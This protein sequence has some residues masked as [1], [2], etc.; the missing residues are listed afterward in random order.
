MDPSERRI[1]ALHLA[2]GWAKLLITLSTGA[3]ALG[4]TF[5]KDIFKGEIT[6]SYLIITSWS[7]FGLSVIFGVFHVGGLIS[8]LNS[9]F[10]S[11]VD[12]DSGQGKIFRT[13][14]GISFFLGVIL[15]V[16]FAS[17]NIYTRSEKEEDIRSYF[18]CIRDNEAALSTFF[19]AMPK[20]G[21]LHNHFSGSVYAETYWQQIIDQNFYIDTSSLVVIKTLELVDP[22]K[23]GKFVTM[24]SLKARKRLPIYQNKLIREWSIKDFDKSRASAANH[25]FDSFKK[26]PGG[27]WSEIET[28]MKEIADRAEKE[29]VQYIEIMVKSVSF[30]IKPDATWNSRLRSLW[31]KNDTTE[32][33]NSLEELTGFLKSNKIDDYVKQHVD[34]IN[35][36]HEK[37]KDRA[38]TFRYLSFIKR[39]TEPSLAFGGLL[40][41]FQAAERSNLIVGVNI[42]ER[43]DGPLSMKDYD[44]HMVMFRYLRS[45]FPNVK[46]SLHAGELSLGLVKPEDLTSHIR[47][48]LFIAGAHRIGHGVDISYEENVTEILTFM[49]RKKIP[50]EINLSSN[51]FILDVKGNHHPISLYRKYG[52]P[53]VISTDDAGILRTNLAHQ[54]VLLATRYRSLSYDDIKSII[55]NSID[56]SFIEED[57]LRKDLR[58]SLVEKMEMFEKS[59]IRID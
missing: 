38:V 31:L 35:M 14:Q 11:N 15:F 3:I 10:N 40:A 34:Q 39:E 37:L 26:F 4:G 55:F 45:K 41:A 28:G 1:K 43:E 6:A 51:E 49:K 19:T 46:C 25:F 33:W 32:L 13:A 59:I 50:V 18:E 27:G 2:T 9:R 22:K 30:D 21:D 54:Y 8:T 7:F 36:L 58:R 42:V 16:V 53:I 29:N 48:A 20:G 52:V 57:D 47:N 12:I 24:N 56:H 44:L 23:K 5:I 17:L